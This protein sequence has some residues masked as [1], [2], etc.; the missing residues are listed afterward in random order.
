MSNENLGKHSWL[1]YPL[2]LVLVVPLSI[3]LFIEC[4]IFL[5]DKD[6]T[7]YILS[8]LAQS[9]AAIIAVA[10]TLSLVVVQFTATTYHPDVLEIFRKRPD[11]WILMVSYVLTIIYS[12]VVLKMIR[13]ADG[14]VIPGYHINLA[15][16]FGFFCL[17][18]L[19]PYSYILLGRLKPSAIIKKLAEKI[20]KQS[21]LSTDPVYPLI[22]VAIRSLQVYDLDTAHLG[23]NEVKD[24]VV[25]IFRTEELNDEEDQKI[26]GKVLKNHLYRTANL[27]IE[28]DNQEST[29]RVIAAVSS[30]GKEAIEQKLHSTTRESLWLLGYIGT[31]AAD[32]YH[33]WA[34]EVALTYLFNLSSNTVEW[35]K[36]LLQ[37][38]QSNETKFSER[39]LVAILKCSVDD[40]KKIHTIAG[41]RKNMN[42]VSKKDWERI[43]TDALRYYESLDKEIKDLH[44]DTF[45]SSDD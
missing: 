43:E 35:L 4:D 29:I 40:L 5:T 22:Q 16:S 26:S 8:A 31:Q 20:D 7:Y 41:D 34:T 2:L 19:I 14:E 18:A 6:G 12:I 17:L 13:G 15:C 28:N 11:L 42:T 9:E 38:A 32:H 25:R 21:L 23:I 30:I 27:A 39:L 45:Y 24:A 10:V 1:V 33:S 44:L 37:V 3:Y 36:D